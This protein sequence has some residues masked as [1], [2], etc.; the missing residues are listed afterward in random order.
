MKS[1]SDCVKPSPPP[2]TQPASQPPQQKVEGVETSKDKD[3]ATSSNGADVPK[4]KS[5]P[6]TPSEGN[7]GKTESPSRRGSQVSGRFFILIL[8]EL[9]VRGSSR[10]DQTDRFIFTVH[11]YYNALMVLGAAEYYD[12]LG[13][14]LQFSFFRES[15]GQ[16]F[17]LAFRQ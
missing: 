11:I 16:R 14:L 12:L 3:E 10:N 1:A 7:E 13:T 15:F 17:E 8:R 5:R 6:H 9:G 2:P 4:A